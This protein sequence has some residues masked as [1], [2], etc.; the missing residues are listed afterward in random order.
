MKADLEKFYQEITDDPLLMQQFESITHQ[1]QFV[2]L[3]IRLAAV[4]GYT[5]TASELED[6]IEASTASEQGE[7]FC[8][9]IGCWHKAELA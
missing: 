2:K 7:Y 9:P 8:L 6:A 5:F 3:A 1:K 4:R